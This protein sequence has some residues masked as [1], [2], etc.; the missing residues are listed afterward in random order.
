VGE[1]KYRVCLFTSFTEDGLVCQLFGGERP[2]VGAVVLSIPRPSL[3]DKAQLSCNSSVLSMLGH[4]E[5]E[6]AKPVAEKLA[7]H[8][9]QPVVLVAGLHIDNA[10]GEDIHTLVGHCWQAVQN[11][12]E[13]R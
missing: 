12:L 13:N 11:L 4:K 9:G 1:G 7:K 10:T 5:D 6:I 8:F 3:L 2:H